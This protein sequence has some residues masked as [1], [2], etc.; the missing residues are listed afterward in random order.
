[1]ARIHLFELG[2][3][4][5]FPR[6]W[7]QY[8]TDYMAFIE[9]RV[10]KTLLV[11][12]PLLERLLARSDRRR[13][14]DLCS[15]GAGPWP[16]LSE[17]L[18]TS[19]RGPVTVTL[20]DLEP[21]LPALERARAHGRGHIEIVA[22]PVDASQVPESLVG[23]RTIFNGFHH[24]RPELARA[25]LADAARARQ[26]IGIFE[27][28]SPSLL[29]AL[30]SPIIVLVVMLATPFIGPFSLGRLFWTFIIPVVPLATWWDGMVSNLP[31]YSDDE[32]RALVAQIDAPGYTWEIARIPSGPFKVPY[33]LGYPGDESR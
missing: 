6:R 1:M 31:V 2:D 20:T 14:V 13:V 11:F 17:S 15:G 22:T 27:L 10:P 32:L 7:H 25:V 24:M 3:M 30:F 28:T 9:K 16:V 19:E 29:H 33:L 4:A 21:N 12:L 26:P 18:A 23:A 8:M 5:W